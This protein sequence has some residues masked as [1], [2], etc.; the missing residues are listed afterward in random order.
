MRERAIRSGN[1]PAPRNGL[2]PLA[3]LLGSTRIAIRVA[4]VFR[5]ITRIFAPIRRRQRSGREMAN[6]REIYGED[7]A[8]L[9]VTIS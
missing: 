3:I 1:S 6:Y 5:P 2:V 9:I 7:G 8:R 4:C